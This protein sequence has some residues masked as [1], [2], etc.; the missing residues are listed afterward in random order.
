M[1]KVKRFFELK[2]QWKQS[3]EADRS[4]IDRQITELMD[5]MTG[6]EVEQL[7][8]GVQ[9]DFDNVH[10]E[11]AEIKEQLTIRERLEPVLPY[12]SVSKLSKDYFNKSSS[13]FYQRLNGNKIHGKVCR[14]T[15]KELETLD[16]ALKDISQRLSS[17]Q[18]V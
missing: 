3:A 4:S 8:V 12:L 7:A 16:M 17:L 15:D 10:Q 6:Q 11:I 1:N 9:N 2:K 13:W 18:L 5:S 14:F